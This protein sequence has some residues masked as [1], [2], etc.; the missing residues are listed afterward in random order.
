[1]MLQADG[2][3]GFRERLGHAVPASYPYTLRYGE[4]NAEGRYHATL[5]GDDQTSG[6]AVQMGER[7][8]T[9]KDFVD[10]PLRDGGGFV[11]RFVARTGMN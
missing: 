5:V 10:V 2:E 3:G 6:A 9:A 8:V 11:A 1:M 4:D 7:E